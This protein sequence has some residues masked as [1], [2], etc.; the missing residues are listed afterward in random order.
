[1]NSTLS[2]QLLFVTNG[3]IGVLTFPILTTNKNNR[4]CLTGTF[5]N[6]TDNLAPTAIPGDLLHQ[7]I[8][9]LVP[10]ALATKYDLPVL[11]ADPLTLEPPP[12]STVGAGP[13]RLHYIFTHPAFAPV[14]AVLPATFLVPIGILAPLG[15]DFSTPD[16]SEAAFPCEAG[17]AWIKSVTHLL[18]HHAGQ[19]I[20]RDPSVF[21]LTDLDLS[22]FTGHN[23][24][25]LV[26]TDYAMLNPT[27]EQYGFVLAVASQRGNH[28]PSSSGAPPGHRYQNSQ[29]GSRAPSQGHE[30]HRQGCYRHSWA[31]YQR[32]P[33]PHQLR[34]P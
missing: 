9:A 16:I 28:S 7:S 11:T 12:P 22:P 24:V 17:R 25:P 4:P 1:M 13:D 14:I 31:S 32:G 29:R 15:W 30:R 21:T 18:T 33:V 26:S 19:S 27:E 23:L 5:G 6:D 20:L 3:T 8:S 34:D 2:N 10:T